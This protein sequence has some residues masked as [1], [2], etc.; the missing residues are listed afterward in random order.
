MARNVAQVRID[1]V[2]R[3][4]G[5]LFIIT[6]LPASRA[7]KWAMKAFLAMAKNGIELPDGIEFS[8]MAGI[9]KIGL[10]LITQLPFD[11][12]E[13]LM[14]EMFTCVQIAPNPSNLSVMRALIEDDVEEI[15]TRIKLRIEV[16][17]LHTSFSSAAG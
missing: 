5:K 7:E 10:K 14:D 15:S 4:N 16:F 2:G 8:G 3:D 9:A 12:A 13:E 11:M 1:A 6:E 17:K